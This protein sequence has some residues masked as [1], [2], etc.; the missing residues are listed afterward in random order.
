M[1]DSEINAGLEQLKENVNDF[2]NALLE[3]IQSKKKMMPEKT[4][5]SE[6]VTIDQLNGKLKNTPIAIIGMASLFPKAENLQQYWENIINSVDCITD[7][8]SSH[9]DADDYY[10]P[11]PF[12]RDKTY[13]KRGGFIPDVKLN[14]MEYG[15][16]PN[17]LEVTDVSQL[18]SLVVAT[19]AMEDAGYGKSRE[20][21]RDAVGVIL[22]AALARSIGSGFSARQQFPIWEKAL[23]S[24]G[25]SD[26]DTQK[27]I[28]KIKSYYPEW[29]ENAFPG[30]LAN[31][32]SG[33]ITNR[34][35]FGGTNCVID[36]ACASSLA[37][38]KMAISELLE[39]QCE[40]ML[41]GGVDVDNSQFTYL[42]FSKTPALSLKQQTRPFDVES[43][44]MMLGEGIGMLVLKRLSD[45]K[46]DGDKIYSVIKGIGTSSDGKYKSIYAPRPEGQVKALKRA[47]QE[48]GFSPTTVGLIEAHGTGT[49]AGDPAEFK[50]LATVFSE[51][52]PQKQHVAIGSVKSQIGHTKAAA[53]SASLIKAALALHHKVL[54]PTINVNKPNP[55]LEIEKSP[56]YVN[57]ETRPWIRGEGEAPRR[58]G[59][60]SFGF[61]GTNY[62]IVLEEYQG[63]H[64]QVYRL[65]KTPQPILLNAPTPAQLSTKCED[66]LG[67][68]QSDKADQH[69]VELIEAC[70]DLQIPLTDARVGFVA[71][72]LAQAQKKLQ[73]CLDSLKRQPEAQDWTHPQGIFYRQTGLELKGK[74]VALFSGQGSQY[75]NMG[76]EL[77]MNF[78][79]LRQ[80]FGH[81]DNLLAEDGFKPLSEVVF[82]RPAFEQAEKAAQVSLLQRTEYAQPAIGSISV[83]MYK[84][85]EKAGFKPDFVAGHSFGEL[86]A[87]W[88]AGVL[89]DKDYFFL[90]KARGQAMATPEDAQADAGGMLAVKGA[91]SKVEAVLKDFPQVSVAN[92]NSNNQVVL[93]G[94]KSEIVKLQQTLTDQGFYAVVLPVSAAFHTPLVAHGQEPFAR[95]VKTVTTQTAEIPIY[96]NVTGELYPSQ[97]QGIQKNL[98]EHLSK[99]VFFKREIENIYAEGGYCFVE[100]GPRSILTNLVKEILAD[101][102]HLAISLNA[103]RQK[104]SDLQMR[105]A[106]M[107]LRVAGVSLQN[108]D[109]Y[110]MPPKVAEAPQGKVLN[111]SMNGANHVSEKTKKAFE[112]ALQDGHKVKTIVQAAENP[113]QNKA[114]LVSPAPQAKVEVKPEISAPPTLAKAQQNGH[115]PV[116]ATQPTPEKAQQNGHRPVAAT[117]T[118]SQSNPSTLSSKSM[119]TAQEQG[120]LVPTQAPNYER[121][122]NSIE[123]SLA[124]FNHHQGDTLQVHEQYLNHQMEYSKTFFQLMLQQQNLL[125]TNSKVAAQSE[126]NKPVVRVLESS[127]RSMMRFHDHQGETLRIHEEYLNQQLEYAK[128][129]F[130]LMQQQYGLLL[131]GASFAQAVA[132][133]PTQL[134]ETHSQPKPIFTPPAQL[135]SP[136]VPAPVETFP[137][138]TNNG[139]KNGHK[140]IISTVNSNGAMAVEASQIAIAELELAAAQPKQPVVTPTVAPVEPVAPTPAPVASP[141]AIEIDFDQ[142]CQTLLEVVSDKTGYPAEMLEMDMD[143][144]ADLGIDSIKRV[145]ILGA[146][147]EQYPQLPKPNLEE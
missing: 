86:T 68:L 34:L 2:E 76:R 63:E 30:L 118:I 29:N 13:C 134:P 104:D 8:P 101:K 16:P 40:M 33:R 58:A 12:A 117:K 53:G 133:T 59:V 110:Q 11:D 22:G 131:K 60:S 27:I 109:S 4:T 143:M 129:F 15:L 122:L 70:K 44:G 105:E 103:S 83:G 137:V 135:D 73:A 142:L 42:C 114:G 77:V 111:V 139:H 36:A 99:P 91:L 141:A 116:A 115:H 14:L 85:L 106:V 97:P 138:A 96:T 20:F 119:N 7:L 69:Y 3:Q 146:L 47:Y 10:D 55:K 32:I 43:D 123:S 81:F 79:E 144:E 49:A 88:A 51:D 95:A 19:Q 38:L 93:A 94:V 90:V 145:E 23:K 66:L 102:P 108:P 78:P 120:Q 80:I 41:T 62:H 126:D 89:N 54:P 31:I 6:Q 147:Q 121:I 65:H 67:K 18:L 140:E 128:N 75:P 125:F 74:V 113:S 24:S 35:D 48:A 100:F 17:I 26:E 50:A 84:I 25:L 136:V 98:E 107:Q 56:F 52:N 45:A 124:Q 28:D 57:T 61:G 71:D 82:P 127:E 87:L 72:S 5:N 92:L 46:R 1:F 39:G 64:E 37:A 112:K 132:A 9:W 130:Q 21:N